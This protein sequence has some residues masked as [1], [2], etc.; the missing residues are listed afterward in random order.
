MTFPILLASCMKHNYNDYTVLAELM[1][2][3]SMQ[4]LKDAGYRGPGL[5][6]I[7]ADLKIERR[8][9]SVLDDGKILKTV[10]TMESEEMLQNTYG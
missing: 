6:A 2:V 8:G 1:Y 4:N 5:D 10:C 7:C 9:H 3:D